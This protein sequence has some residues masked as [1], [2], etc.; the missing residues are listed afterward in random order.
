VKK[1]KDKIKRDL[2]TYQAPGDKVMGK[3]VLVIPILV[4]VALGLAGFVLEAGWKYLY[5]DNPHFS[6]VA[7][8]FTPTPN[9]SA[10]QIIEELKILGIE[11]R[12]TTL[13]HLNLKKIRSHFQSNALVE[14]IQLRRILPGTLEIVIKEREPAAWLKCNPPLAMSK[15]GFILPHSLKNAPTGLPNIIGIPEPDKLKIG[16][17]TDNQMLLGALHFLDI[18]SLRPEPYLRKVSLIQLDSANR[19]LIL[20]MSGDEVFTSGAQVTI[21]IREMIVALER[22][23][24]IVSERAQAGKTISRTDVTITRNIPVSP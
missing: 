3:G 11:E 7:V 10:E 23:R 20:F 9:F 16:E 6:L 19:N 5:A 24:G 2:T 18:A 21:P 12:Q 13:P 4:L 17:K 8:R 14:D 15:R 1:K 22:L